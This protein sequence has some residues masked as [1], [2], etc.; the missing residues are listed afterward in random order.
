MGILDRVLLGGDHPDP[1]DRAAA[2]GRV[3]RRR[4]V[5]AGR[6]HL[7]LRLDG[8]GPDGRQRL[9]PGA[10]R[11]ARG[12]PSLL[13]ARGRQR[14]GRG[15]ARRS[16]PCPRPD[17]RAGRRE[18]RPRARGRADGARDRRHRHQGA[19]LP[20]LREPALGR[21]RRAL[22]VLRQLHDGLPDLLLH[23]RRGRHRSGGEHVE[24]HQRWDSCFTVDY[25]HIHGGAVRAPR[26][27]A[28]ASG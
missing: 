1:A 16:A 23:D 12:R 18:Q 6:R 24:R 26:A 10:H 27:R 13:R 21:G 3:R 7:L 28:T 11:G 9:R 14:A 20:Q 25:S 4:P 17:G 2:R 5:R 8:H 22:P 19:A 15:A